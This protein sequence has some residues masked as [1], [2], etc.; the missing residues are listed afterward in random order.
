MA[1]TNKPLLPCLVR[2]FT[3]IISFVISASRRSNST[4]HVLLSCLNSTINCRLLNFFDRKIPPNSNF[5]EGVSSHDVIV[6]PHRQSLVSPIYPLFRLVT[7]IQSHSSIS[8]L[9]SIANTSLPIFV[10]F[11]DDI[12]HSFSRSFPVII[13]LVGLRLA[14][15]HRFPSQ[16]NDGLKIL[17]ILNL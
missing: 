2:L 14:P 7:K 13:V 1:L 6:D 15:E 3:S 12:C 11:H 5:V 10:F 17:K 4:R 8:P 16:Y 9:D